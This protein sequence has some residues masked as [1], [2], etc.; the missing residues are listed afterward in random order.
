MNSPEHNEQCALFQW[1]EYSKGVIPE[2]NNIF[3][4]PNG[5]QRHVV[6]AMKLKAEGVRAGIPDIFLAF[7][8]GGWSGLFIEM[9]AG[10]NRTSP[11][12]NEWIMRLQQAN[13]MVVVCYSFEQ[14][15]Q[16]ILDYLE[17]KE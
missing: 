13:Y 5:G 17:V 7:P 16:N 8:W 9:K 4:I 3:A 15:K 11:A 1:V 12:Q 14:A 2:L 6:V 10:K